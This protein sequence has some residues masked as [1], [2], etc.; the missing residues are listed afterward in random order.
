MN[1]PARAVDLN[2]TVLETVAVD[3]SGDWWTGVVRYRPRHGSGSRLRLERYVENGGGVQLAHRWRVRSEFWTDERDAVARFRK[4]GGDSPPA[5]PI[6]D[7]FDVREYTEI[8][9]DRTRWV[10]VSRIEGQY[11]RDKARL[12]HWD[13]S[14]RTT[15]QKWTVGKHWSRLARVATRM[16]A[17]GA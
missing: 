6:S 1:D 4:Y 5:L 15:E 12:Y 10:G 9:N 7:F 2:R 11:G 3:D 8:R 13:P 17:E 14:D 16:L